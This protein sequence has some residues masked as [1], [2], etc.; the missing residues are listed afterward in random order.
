MHCVLILVHEKAHTAFVY[1]EVYG[2]TNESER[3][4]RENRP[5]GYSEVEYQICH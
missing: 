4:R 3:R 5:Q 2:R 1:E